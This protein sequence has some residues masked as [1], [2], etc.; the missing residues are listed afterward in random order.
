MAYEGSR[1]VG[2]T[3]HLFE[4]RPWH[5]MVPDQSALASEQGE[6]THRVVA[7]RAED[8]SFVIAYTPVGQPLSIRLDKLNG[9]RINARWYDPRNGTWKSIGP[10]PSEGT[11]EFVPPSHGELDDWVLV[12]DAM[13]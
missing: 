10:S 1:Q 9:P 12:L 2:L 11:Q 4:Q 7:G 13:P 8:G 5:K 3:R 6:G